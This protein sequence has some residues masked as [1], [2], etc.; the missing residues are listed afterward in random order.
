MAKRVTGIS[1][2]ATK[3]LL[4]ELAQ[5]YSAKTAVEIAIESV[6]GVTAAD[7]ARAGEA[8]DVVALAIGA[9]RKLEADG[10]VVAGSIVEVARSPMA[11]A[12]RAGAARPDIA[13]EAG[14]RAAV[15]AAGAI[16]Y[17]TGPS[18][19][20]FRKVLDGWGLLERLSDR[21]TVA[22]PGVP[23]AALIARGAVD[24]GV[25]QL[26]ELQ[27]VEGVDVVG[28][29]PGAAQLVTTFAAGLGARAVEADAARAF[30]AYLASPD[31][32]PVR[33]RHGMQ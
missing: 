23:V 2:M 29:L 8:F 25:Q 7:R 10:H 11:V 12:V 27:N 21:L 3:N 15:E 1:S 20:H 30:L 28:E 19:D 4:A 16:G 32:A 33:R 18:G 26:S 9:L 17:S 13:D 5:L 6:G 31:T 22:T 24:I 14:F